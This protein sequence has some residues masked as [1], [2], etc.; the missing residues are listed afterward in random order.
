[1]E[2]APQ[3]ESTLQ[4]AM[5]ESAAHSLLNASGDATADAN[6]VVGKA[7]APASSGASGG[8][9][10]VRKYTCYRK[11]LK[12]FC[13]YKRASRPSFSVRRFSELAGI[14]SPNSLQMVIQGKRNMSEDL[15]ASVARAMGLLGAERTYFV[16]L[17]RS[18]NAKSPEQKEDANR[19]LLRAVKRLVARNVSS[20]QAQVLSCWQHPVVRE[21]AFLPDFE[22]RGEWISKK[23]RGLISPRQAEESLALLVNA[24]FLEKT[25]DNR[26]EV[27]DP[28]VDT[29]DNFD[30]A[31][32]LQMHQQ[33]LKV[34][35]EM[36][37]A[38]SMDERELG[39]LNI[40]ISSDKIPE[41]KE[42]IRAFQDEIIGWL[43]SEQSPDRVVQL[44][45]YLMPISL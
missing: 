13:E 36:L 15:A 4:Q 20:A 19:G 16:A 27:R 1:M 12:D 3:T 38:L 40:P 28:V 17:I 43:S 32:V 42:R 35:Q 9:P 39:L 25:A 14:K 2:L 31:R 21:L 30:F 33:N 37:G 23:L 5:P 8:R 41:F 18:S 45:V 7:P 22:A 34:W 10:N 29:G 11:F 44:G 6:A 24:G 26:I